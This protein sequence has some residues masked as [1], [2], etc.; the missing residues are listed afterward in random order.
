VSGVHGQFVLTC[1]DDNRGSE[2]LKI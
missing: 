2:L 1:D